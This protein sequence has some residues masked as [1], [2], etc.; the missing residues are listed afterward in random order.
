MPWIQGRRYRGLLILLLRLSIMIYIIF[1]GRLL[2]VVRLFILKTFCNCWRLLVIAWLLRM[3][4]QRFALSLINSIVCLK[5]TIFHFI[6]SL[7]IIGSLGPLSSILIPVWSPLMV[8]CPHREEETPLL[9][10]KG[11][12]KLSLNLCPLEMILPIEIQGEEEE[13]LRLLP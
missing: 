13:Y 10:H 9:P 7:E 1:L 5:M 2:L 4:S 11:P 12:A 6:L 3:L 8:Q